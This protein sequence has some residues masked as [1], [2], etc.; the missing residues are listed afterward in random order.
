V[1]YKFLE[2]I[3]LFTAEKIGPSLPLS[4]ESKV[5]LRTSWDVCTKAF[6][7]LDPVFPIRLGR[8]TSICLG[9][10]AAFFEREKSGALAADLLVQSFP[11]EK[12][13]I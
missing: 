7:L 4:S 8:P 9:P 6:S 2:I 11:M 13:I 10:F 3:C 12:H 1:T 5:L